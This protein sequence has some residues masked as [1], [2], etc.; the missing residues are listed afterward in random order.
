M[1][2]RDRVGEELLTLP[3]IRYSFKYVFLELLSQI[4]EPDEDVFEI[5]HKYLRIAEW[6]NSFFNIV[7]RGKKAYVS[8]LRECGELEN[9][10][11]VENKVN[12]VIELY[13]SI[14]PDY[15]DNDINSL[16]KYCLLYTSRC[17]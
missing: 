7:V 4:A 3:N 5:V 14:S 9:W 17:V 11:N 1:C 2:I 13:A 15:A 10:I 12:K 8:K 6:E 16:E